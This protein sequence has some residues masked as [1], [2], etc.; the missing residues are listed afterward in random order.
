MLIIFAAVVVCLLIKDNP[1]KALKEGLKNKQTHGNLLEREDRLWFR[2][3]K[4]PPR[5][6]K[7]GW[8]TEC[9]GL[10]R[11][12]ETT[13]C[14]HGD[15]ILAWELVSRLS[16]LSL[17]SPP[18]CFPV[19]CWLTGSPAHIWPLTLCSSLISCSCLHG[20]CDFV[21]TSLR[22]HWHVSVLLKKKRVHQSGVGWESR[23][24][25]ENNHDSFYT[26]QAAVS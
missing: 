19:A 26:K 21:K 16:P 15:F 9:Q 11:G 1:I 2:S 18:R 25:K 5:L 6:Y 7:Q 14:H 20:C 22:F 8:R 4:P 3:G 12:A 10:G 17:S 13:T 24:N 23:H